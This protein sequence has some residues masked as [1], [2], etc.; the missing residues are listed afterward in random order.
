MFYQ[1]C[2]TIHYFLYINQNCILSCWNT[3]KILVYIPQKWTM[4]AHLFKLTYI[5]YFKIMPSLET[6]ICI[7][8][9]LCSI[10]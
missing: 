5:F 9:Y 7:P 6:V 3:V 8:G 1:K 10:W 4:I 2:A